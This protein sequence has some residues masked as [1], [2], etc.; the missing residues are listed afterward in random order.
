MRILTNGTRIRNGEF[1]MNVKVPQNSSAIIV[2]N[3]V[4]SNGYAQYYGAL[5]NNRFDPS[6]VECT[7]PECNCRTKPTPSPT[8]APTTAPTTAPTPSPP[9]N[10]LPRCTH[11]IVA[12]RLTD[13]LSDARHFRGDRLSDATAHT[14]TAKPHQQNLFCAHGGLCCRRHRWRG[15]GVHCDPTEKPFVVAVAVASR[16]VTMKRRRGA[17]HARQKRLPSHRWRLPR[18]QW[19]DRATHAR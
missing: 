15:I 18:T 12:D 9:T 1:F 4:S 13:R 7:V 10:A 14:N 17:N 8:A 19:C 16:R 6:A 5:A 3:C 11:T 2:P